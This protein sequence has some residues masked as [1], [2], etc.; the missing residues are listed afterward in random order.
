MNGSTSPMVGHSD[1]STLASFLAAYRQAR[2]R[3]AVHREV[4]GSRLSFL[5]EQIAA[6]RAE[7]SQPVVA[8]PPNV[9]RDRLAAFLAKLARSWAL[10]GPDTRQLNVWRIA[11]L[12]RHE[13][14]TS[15][16]LRWLLDARES[17]GL[18]PAILH[19]LLRRLG[20]RASK[21]DLTAF[22]DGPVHSV[23]V[24]YN[25]FGNLDSRVDLVLENDRSVIFIEV[26]IDAPPGP[27]QLARYVALAHR[28]ARAMRHERWI[29]LYLSEWKP[30]DTDGLVWLQWRDVAAVVRA[31]VSATGAVGT[32]AAVLLQ[33]ADHVQSL[34]RGQRHDPH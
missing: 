28:K 33:F 29:V 24:E 14:R 18:G 7:L 4:S 11:S 6:A 23:S 17:H 31:G 34:H 10:T 30:P 9:D 25:V 32:P 26:K 19:G 13:V 21:P 8:L 2:A 3:P 22:I 15:S 27:D 16:V 5:L 12:G 1:G 20:A